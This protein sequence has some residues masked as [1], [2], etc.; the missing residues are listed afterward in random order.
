MLFFSI[1]IVKLMMVRHAY[2]LKPRE[3]VV[4]AIAMLAL[5]QPSIE[6]LGSVAIIDTLCILKSVFFLV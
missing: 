3:Y 6:L 1:S 5:C 4:R 2:I